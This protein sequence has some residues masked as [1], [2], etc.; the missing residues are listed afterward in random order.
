MSVT[1]DHVN[2]VLP[3]MIGLMTIVVPVYL[4]L[5]GKIVNMVNL[6]IFRSGFS[7]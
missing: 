3:V 5:L 1:A 6:N 4:D 2:M 7:L